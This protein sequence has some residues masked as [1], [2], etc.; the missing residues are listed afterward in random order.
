MNYKLF[1]LAIICSNLIGCA[2]ITTGQNQS[3]SVNT[4]QHT[5]ATCELANDDGTWY[6][7]STPGSVTVNRSYSNLNI[8]C[9]KGEKAGSISV[10][11]K[12]KGM[13]FGNIIAGGIVG[14]AVDAGTGA[15][16][17]YSINIHVP[18]KS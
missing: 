18:L 7:S 6:V 4:G 13:A 5:G 17:D 3:V 11:S 9:K 2:S 16:Y 15:T 8:S 14:A 10:E 1:I 12:T